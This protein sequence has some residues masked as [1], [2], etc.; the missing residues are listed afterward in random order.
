MGSETQGVMNSDLG[1]TKQWPNN[2]GNELIF[3]NFAGLF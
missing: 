3:P 2:L 1:T